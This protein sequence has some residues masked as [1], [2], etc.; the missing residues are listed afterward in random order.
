[1][2]NS[3]TNS[4]DATLQG[5]FEGRVP[6]DWFAGAPE[7]THD[8]DEIVLI[9]TLADPGT[10]TKG[11]DADARRAAARQGRIEGF[12]EDTR[13]LRMRIAD[14]AEAR[15]ARKVAW[16]VRCG[17]QEEIFT[18]LSVPVMTRLRLPERRVLDTLVD[19]GVAR[20][21]SHAL[22]WCVRL[23]GD[24]EGDW[25]TQLREALVHVQKVRD[26]RPERK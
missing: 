16:G 10:D 6:A 5:W 18:N 26:D 8:R 20:S 7:V 21:R 22:A 17:D 2:T 19:A 23:V 24:H 9:G 1:M 13:Q 11:A 14:E 15:F 3:R 4:N 12:R 25:I